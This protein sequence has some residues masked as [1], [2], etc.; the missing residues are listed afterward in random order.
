MFSRRYRD[1]EIDE[2]LQNGLL[3]RLMA[4]A[5]RFYLEL[6]STI[7]QLAFDHSDLWEQGPAKAMLRFHLDKLLTICQNSLTRKALVLQT[8]AYLRDARVKSFYHESM[9]ESLW[10]RL[11][12]LS[13]RGP[14]DSD[15]SGGATGGSGGGP[16]GG[17]GGGTGATRKARTTGTKAKTRGGAASTNNTNEAAQTP[18]CSHCKSS[19]LHKLMSVRLAKTFCPLKHMG[20]NKARN[21]AGHAIGQWELQPPPEGV[22]FSTVLETSEEDWVHYQEDG[23][24]G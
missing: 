2:Y 6:L 12:T 22:G 14:D 23:D 9:T 17:G 5:F 13:R 7:R 20:T 15:Y 24:D 3:P 19:K 8:Y 10:D 11:A 16:S 21:V 1:A 18:K 4:T